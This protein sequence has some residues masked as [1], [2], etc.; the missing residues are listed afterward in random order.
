MR[1]Y[2]YK[3]GLSQLKVNECSGAIGQGR[4]G[5][6]PETSADPRKVWKAGGAA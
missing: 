4:A 5:S 2:V 1:G 3:V 6:R